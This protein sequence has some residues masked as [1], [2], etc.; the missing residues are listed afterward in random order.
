VALHAAVIATSTP[1]EVRVQRFSDTALAGY[2]RRAAAILEYEGGPALAAYLDRLERETRIHA[3][4]ID[5]CGRARL[6][7]VA[8]GRRLRAEG[9]PAGAAATSWEIWRATSIGWPSG[10]RRS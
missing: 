6:R 10:S 2:G 3:V 5:A 8:G 4:L 9:S 7:R 1:T